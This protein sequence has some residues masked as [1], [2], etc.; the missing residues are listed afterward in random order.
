MHK[1]LDIDIKN[2]SKIEGHAS[3]EIKVRKGE[4]EKVKLIVG[5]NKRFYEEALKNKNYSTV[6]QMVSRICGTCSVAHLTCASEA[7]E[8][9]LNIKLS[10]QTMLMRKLATLGTILRDHA[11]HLYL[12]VLPDVLGRDSVL[13]FDKK[14]HRFVHYAFILKSAGNKIT[15]IVCGR[16]IHSIYALLG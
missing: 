3:L 4:V 11:M 5:E 1:N 6:P 7:I 8:N 10:R 2:L 15:I 9:A 12:F 13:D 16:A 14:Q